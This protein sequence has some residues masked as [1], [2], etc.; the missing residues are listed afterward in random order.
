L[1]LVLAVALASVLALVLDHHMKL[2]EV[3][4]Q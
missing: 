2:K 4:P 3:R 1:V